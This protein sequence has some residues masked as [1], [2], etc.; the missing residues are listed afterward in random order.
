MEEQETSTKS[1]ALQRFLKY[2]FFIGAF[3]IIMLGLLAFLFYRVSINN[4][5]ESAIDHHS[6]SDYDSAYENL[7][8]LSLPHDDPQKLEVYAQTM[9]AT[10]H[11][12]E[13]E[14][15]YSRL[16]EVKQDPF[17][18]IVLGNVK[19]E[20]GDFEAAARIYSELI[21]ANPQYAQAYINLATLHKTQ[22]DLAQAIEVAEQGTTNNPQNVVLHQL[23]VSLLMTDKESENYQDAVAKLKELNP[24]DP[25]LETLNEN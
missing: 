20:Q 25:L 23:L 3:V 19:N 15:A 7:K 17:S 16:Y 10:N 2:K 22:G 4:S 9:L 1:S 12:E 8:N 21:D 6:R 18:K 5:W 14:E 13:A 24:N 11:L